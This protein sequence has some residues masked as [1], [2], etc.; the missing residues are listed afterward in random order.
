MRRTR[1]RTLTIALLLAATL[2]AGCEPAPV[3]PQQR[4]YARLS[5][6][7]A[8]DIPPVSPANPEPPT[9]VP[10]MGAPAD[11]PAVI[12]GRRVVEAKIY[13]VVEGQRMLEVLLD[14]QGTQV[15]TDVTKKHRGDQL[16]F[17]LDGRVLSAPRVNQMIDTG[18]F[19]VPVDYVVTSVQGEPK[20][21]PLP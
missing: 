20:L 21:T 10:G 9:F 5:I 3:I 19:A 1:I 13:D 6:I 16:L 18:H 4:W 15:F 2:L 17:C 11:T 7:S 14:D 8:A 12:D